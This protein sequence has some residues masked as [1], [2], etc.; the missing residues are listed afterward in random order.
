MKQRMTI[1]QL[2]ERVQTVWDEARGDRDMPRRGDID[3]DRYARE[4]MK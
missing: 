1:D 4:P 3:H 2:L